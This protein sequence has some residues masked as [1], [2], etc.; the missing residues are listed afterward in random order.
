MYV[1]VVDGWTAGAELPATFALISHQ[2]RKMGDWPREAKLE[3]LRKFPVC[4]PKDVNEAL[5]ET[6]GKVRQAAILLE[7]KRLASMGMDHPMP[8]RRNLM[9]RFIPV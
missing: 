6:G 5:A 9:R 2:L 3:L 1:R 8:S 7:A 4:D